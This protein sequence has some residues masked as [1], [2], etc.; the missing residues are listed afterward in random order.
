MTRDGRLVGIL[1]RSDI[2]RLLLS[3][4]QERLAA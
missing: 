4:A 2:L 3:G 1:T